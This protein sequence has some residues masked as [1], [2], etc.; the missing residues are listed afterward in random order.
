MKRADQG[1]DYVDV[2]SVC[3][4]LYENSITGLEEWLKH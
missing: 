2:T 3:T 4:S 1:D